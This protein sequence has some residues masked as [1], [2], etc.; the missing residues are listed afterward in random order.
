M[1]SHWNSWN[2]NASFPSELPPLRI[3]R[4]FVRENAESL[5]SQSS[6]KKFMFT[7]KK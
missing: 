2:A 3:F 1:P 6:M 7:V 5:I 4:V